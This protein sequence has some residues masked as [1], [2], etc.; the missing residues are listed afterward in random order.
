M[1]SRVRYLICSIN[2]WL[3]LTRRLISMS[4]TAVPPMDGPEFDVLEL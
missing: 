3:E 4:V 2:S 1:P